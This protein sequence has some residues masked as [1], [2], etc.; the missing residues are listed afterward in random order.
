MAGST[1]TSKLLR[2]VRNE[3]DSYAKYESGDLRVIGLPGLEHLDSVVK[4]HMSY[5]DWLEQKNKYTTVKVEGLEKDLSK[6]F[7]SLKVKDIHLFVNQRT[8]YS[9][10]WHCDSL[11]VFLFVLK[12]KKRLEIKNK[13]YILTAGSGVFIPKGHLHRAFS[14]KNTWALSLGLK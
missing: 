2:L 14:R 11:D 12:G 5:L 9:F 6:Y 10:K 7:K 13:T 3:P 1:T 8:S 4:E